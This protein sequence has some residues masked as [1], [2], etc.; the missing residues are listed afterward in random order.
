VAWHDARQFL[1]VA[2]IKTRRYSLSALLLS[3]L[4]LSTLSEPLGCHERRA[5]HENDGSLAQP[6]NRPVSTPELGANLPAQPVGP[7]DLI[8]V[9]VYDAPEMSRTTRVG[10]DGYIRLPMLK[11]RVK[12]QGL[13]PSELET[14]IAE[15]LRGEDILVDPFITV[16]IA[17]YQSRPIT[18]AGAVKMS[19]VFQAESAV[20]LL[21]AISRAQG[22]TNEAGR[23]IL[24]SRSQPGPD[25]KALMLTRRINVR[26]LID[27][28]DPTLNVMLTGGE[29]VRVPEVGKIY[30]MGNVKKPGVFP[31][32]G[33]SD[34]TVMQMLGLAEGLAP[35]AAK[36]AFIYRREA[37][38]PKNELV[39]PL[40]KIMKRQAPDV[41]LT[42]NDILY[43]PDNTGSH[44]CPSSVAPALAPHPPAVPAASSPTPPRPPRPR[45]RD[46]FCCIARRFVAFGPLIEIPH[47]CTIP[48]LILSYAPINSALNIRFNPRLIGPKSLSLNLFRQRQLI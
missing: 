18:V 42:A 31:V 34:T 15:A 43:I 33:G 12:A 8:A 35:F 27:D 26:G 41:T 38:G 13:N 40:D 17:Q 4:S 14:A 28:A 5:R 45:H 29:E 44:A 24:V 3:L 7:N 9:S 30:I 36:Q 20:T 1:S 39:V 2:E 37:A 19:L 21:E 22:L 11:E 48:R 47:F 25:G 23:E 6:P 46:G 10:A 16:T 32:Q